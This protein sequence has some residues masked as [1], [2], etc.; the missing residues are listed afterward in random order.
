MNIK[1]LWID[2]EFEKQQDVIGDAEQDGIDLIP[3]EDHLEGIEALLSDIKGFHAVILDARVKFHKDDKVS[4]LK[5]L[6]A[7]IDKLLILH[8]QG[9]YI[10]FFIFT[11]QPDYMDNDVFIQTYGEYFIKGKDNQK[12]FNSIKDQVQNKEEYIIQYEYKNIFSI[13][14]KYFD[15]EVKKHLT[16]VLCSIKKTNVIFDDK[17][18]FTQIRIILES[19]FRIA[20][21]KG[22]LHDK[23]IPDGK[24]NLN[25]SCTFLSGDSSRHYGVKSS[26]K[27]FPK[28][29]SDAAR[30]IIHITGAAAHTTGEEN[31]NNIDLQEYRKQVKSPFL[32]YSL[33]F[34]LLDIIIW[35]DEYLKTNNDY[36]YNKSLW[37]QDMSKTYIEGEI[38][39]DANGYYY[40]G[41]FL[42]WK[43]IIDDNTFIV[44]DVIQVT[45]A[46]DNTNTATKNNYQFF[47]T[48]FNLKK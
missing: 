17:L 7:S 45:Q 21:T 8:S 20:N 22:L 25:E 1:V 13:C 26:V 4:D 40:C 27:H 46:S 9:H 36:E 41:E 14:E 12:L 19:I 10:P 5:G 43:R 48:R 42:L 11:G 15:T 38:C 47:A 31:K 33:V 16:E 32:L 3:Y 2:D 18:Y 24:V 29:I 34:Q 44:G 23:C 30:S 37:L 28:L 35:F 39:K 6:K